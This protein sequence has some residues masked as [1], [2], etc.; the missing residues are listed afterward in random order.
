MKK[1]KNSEYY[2]QLLSL[3]S[4]TKCRHFTRQFSAVFR[5]ITLRLCSSQEEV[6]LP[7]SPRITFQEDLKVKRINEWR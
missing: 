3:K 2:I 4:C 6:W 1:I 5:L 7:V